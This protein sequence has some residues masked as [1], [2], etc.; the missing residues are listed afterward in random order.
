MRV[1]TLERADSSAI[2]FLANP[3]YRKFLAQTRA[4]AVIVEPKL[5]DACPGAA[6]L[7]TN[8]YATYARI[9]AVLHPA[10]HAAPGTHASAVVDPTAS[11]DASASIG[12][13]AV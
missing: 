2:T 3:K 11:I 9:A 7:A 5:V 13:R 10:S 4:G 8:P 12:P 6:L 1:A